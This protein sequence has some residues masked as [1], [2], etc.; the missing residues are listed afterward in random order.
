M[1]AYLQGVIKKKFDRSIIL[2]T[3]K[4]GYL[5][6]VPTRLIEKLEEQAEFELF[7]FTK[8]REDDISLY[9]F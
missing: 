5:V 7:I 9:G 8:V 6:F 2:D 4:V 1:I 3:G